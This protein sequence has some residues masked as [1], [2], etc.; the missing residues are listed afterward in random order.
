LRAALAAWLDDPP[1]RARWVHGARAAAARLPTWPQAVDRF[2]AA[3]Q[4]LP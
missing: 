1:R 3:L 4:E 2:A